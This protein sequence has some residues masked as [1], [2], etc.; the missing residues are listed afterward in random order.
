MYHA[1]GVGFSE[2]LKN[3]PSHARRRLLNAAAIH[4]VRQSAARHIIHYDE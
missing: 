1:V 4:E 3:L 2:R